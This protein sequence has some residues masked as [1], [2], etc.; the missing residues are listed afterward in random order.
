ML[1]LP[2]GF[3]EGSWSILLFRANHHLALHLFL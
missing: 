1:I 3:Q 2:E